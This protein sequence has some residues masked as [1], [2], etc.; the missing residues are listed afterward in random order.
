[1]DLFTVGKAFC[2]GY[3]LKLKLAE[4]AGLPV[5]AY[6]IKLRL[7]LA[8]MMLRDTLLSVSEIYARV[9]FKDRT[10]FFRLFKKQFGIAPNEYRNKFC[11]MI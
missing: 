10:H 4:V 2:C 11:N 3:K 7:D 5:I 1:M 9:G 8:S 6:L